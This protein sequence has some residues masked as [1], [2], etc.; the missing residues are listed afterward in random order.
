M[1][2]RRL[3]FVLT[4]ISV[5]NALLMGLAGIVLVGRRGALWDLVGAD[6]KCSAAPNARL[7]C[8][9]YSRKSAWL[10]FGSGIGCFV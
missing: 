9:Y 5:G 6:M 7:G 8:L 1:H 3:Y 10:S 4:N 2:K